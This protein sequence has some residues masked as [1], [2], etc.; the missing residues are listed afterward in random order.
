MLLEGNANWKADEWQPLTG[1]SLGHTKF[2]DI[3]ETRLR[4]YRTHDPHYL[5]LLNGREFEALF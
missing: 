3:L 1:E 4:D 5:I 2:G